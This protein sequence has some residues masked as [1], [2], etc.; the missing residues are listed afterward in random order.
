MCTCMATKTI[1]I[2]MEAYDKLRRARVRPSESFSHVIKR[3]RWDE[4]RSTAAA[5]LER[6]E[7][8]P[9]P[10]EQTLEYLEQAQA[11]DELPGNPWTE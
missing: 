11:G 8:V 5:L 7:S 1:S 6:L 2:D 9:V 4:A 3:G 10:D